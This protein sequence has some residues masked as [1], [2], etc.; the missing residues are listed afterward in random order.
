MTE[1]RGV[2]VFFAAWRLWTKL[3]PLPLVF[4]FTGKTGVLQGLVGRL[5]AL[6][7]FFIYR[8]LIHSG[9]RFWGISL[10]LGGGMRSGFCWCQLKILHKEDGSWPKRKK[11]PV[12]PDSVIVLSEIEHRKD[13]EGHLFPLVGYFDYYCQILELFPPFG[14]KKFW[15]DNF[16]R[17]F[18]SISE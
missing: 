2:T 7:G 13:A 14:R 4:F 10:K 5:W 12:S 9:E 3:H 11:W 17:H 16:L 6:K 8:V 1:C 15:P 18:S